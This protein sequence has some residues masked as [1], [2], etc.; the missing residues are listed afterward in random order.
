MDRPLKV[1][2]YMPLFNVVAKPL[3][4]RGVPIGPNGLL[5][6]PGRKTGQPRTTPVAVIEWQGRRWV[7]APWGEVQWVKNLR[8]AKHATVTAHKRPYEYE[9]RELDET[10]RRSF[11]GDVLT[12]LSKQ[13][14][15][16]YWFFRLADGI[17]LHHPDEV[18]KNRR[19][20][21]LLAAD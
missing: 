20:F 8:A 7:W 3:L 16:G 19:V 21:E 5:T 9:A 11:F 18:A 4:R 13:Y 15:G 10:E 1:P 2:W 6:V 14:P 12:S 17:D